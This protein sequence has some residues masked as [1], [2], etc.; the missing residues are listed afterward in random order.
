MAIRLYSVNWMSELKYPFADPPQPGQLLEIIPGIKW[1]RMPLPMQLN[2]INLY[3]LEDDDSAL[4]RFDT[5]R[6]RV[7]ADPA[8]GVFNLIEI[9]YHRAQLYGRNGKAAHACALM[10]SILSYPADD[11]VR[12]RQKGRLEGARK[13]VRKWCEK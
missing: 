7:V 6:A 10:D 3:L 13:F 5:L 8:Q 9:D 12:K 11:D 4:V 1:L 2:H